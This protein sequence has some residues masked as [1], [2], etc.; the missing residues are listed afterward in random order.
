MV[1]ENKEGTSLALLPKVDLGSGVQLTEKVITQLVNYA[2]KYDLDP[3]LGHVVFMYGKP[4]VTL[5][6]Y[7]YHARR[8][9]AAYSLESRPM[10]G[11]EHDAYNLGSTDYGWLATVTLIITQE[12]YTGLGIV[13]YKEIK[14][15]S[16][17]DPQLPAHPVVANNPQLLCQKRAE[18][19]ALRRAF[20]LE[21]E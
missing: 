20:P 5:D 9:G 14:E 7:L 13:T 15:P 19:Q 4:Y 8:S 18:W 16:K 21:G 6:G 10:S 2:K 1:N 17:N 3:E 11:D 12:V